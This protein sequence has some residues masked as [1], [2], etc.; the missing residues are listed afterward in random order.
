MQFEFVYGRSQTELNT[1]VEKK[2]AEGWKRFT[3]EVHAIASGITSE[4]VEVPNFVYFSQ[5]IIK[6]D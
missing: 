5:S 2:I 1:K 3:G 6:E 4:Q